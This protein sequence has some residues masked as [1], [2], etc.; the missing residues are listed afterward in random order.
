VGHNI[1]LFVA[2]PTGEE[3]DD[4][5]YINPTLS[6]AEGEVESEEGC[7]SLPGITAKILR[8]KSVKIRA[9]DPLGQWFEDISDQFPAR[10]WQHEF[11]HLNGTLLMDRMGPL[12]KITARK[13][14]K[15]LEEKWAEQNPKKK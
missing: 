9:Q 12:A 2:N 10:V 1:R 13:P 15:E 5:V 6:D 14:L 7:L 11:D 4:H 3:G 8:A